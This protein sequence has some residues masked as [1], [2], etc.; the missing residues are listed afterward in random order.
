MAE[1]LTR[2]ITVTQEMID[3]YGRLNGD[4]DIIHYDEAYA[5][6]RGYRGTLAHGLMVMAYAAELGARRFGP[7]WFEAGTISAKWTGPVCPGDVLVV[8]LDETG[9]VRASVGDAAVM[10]GEVG[11]AAAV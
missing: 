2:T 8:T 11:V 4:N 10:V 7:C 1:P 3:R 6:Q 9:T 5:R